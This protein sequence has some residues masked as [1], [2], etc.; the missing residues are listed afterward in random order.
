MLLPWRVLGGT[1]ATAGVCTGASFFYLTHGIQFVPLVATDPIF[2]SKYHK[3][4]NPNGNPTIHDLHVK[5]V[6]LSSIDPTLLRDQKK[7]LER[8]CGG[9][10]AGG[11]KRI[12]LLL[13]DGQSL[14]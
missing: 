4:F 10:W 12:F 7:L 13:F 14:S 8:Y 3:K 9:V 1:F 2:Q 11:G 5:R 6:P